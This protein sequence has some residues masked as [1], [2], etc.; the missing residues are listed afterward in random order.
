MSPIQRG[1]APGF[2]EPCE[3]GPDLY[4]IDHPLRLGGVDFGTRT[5]LVR[6]SSG[7]LFVHSPGPLG[8]G[9]KERIES[10]G[11]VRALVAPNC[12]HHLYVEE[13]VRAWPD[14]EL[15]LAPGL[16][17][18][19]PALPAGRTL[20]STPPALWKDDLDQ[21][22][23]RGMPKVGEV[24]F[25]HPK[26]RYLLLT[27]L[28]FNFHHAGGFLARQMLKVMGAWDR[29]G[30]SRLARSFM[31]DKDAIRED[32]DRILEWDFERILLGH[33]DLVERDARAC[34]RESYGEALGR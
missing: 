26:S 15:F 32:I 17:E 20:G 3:R 2:G 4:S 7:G 9:V 29:F 14:A 5:T 30:P 16:A 31:K 28:A 18:K 6:L 1:P 11:P 10:L 27:D 8:G 33:G 24:V 21:V 12:F 25:F 23:V 34:L 13:N 22:A 19:K